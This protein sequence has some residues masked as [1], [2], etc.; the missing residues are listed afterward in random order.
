M[1]SAAEEMMR[2][3]D[4]MDF[5]TISKQVVFRRGCLISLSAGG[6]G[7]VSGFAFIRVIRGPLGEGSFPANDA[8]SRE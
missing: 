4:G 7:T 1:A 3:I 8:N 6:G 5:G 2:F